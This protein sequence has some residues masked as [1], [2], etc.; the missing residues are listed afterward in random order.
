MLVGVVGRTDAG[1]GDSSSLVGEK[2]GIA[3]GAVVCR[4]AGERAGIGGIEV[5]VKAAVECGV[6]PSSP[7]AVNLFAITVAPEG[8]SVPIDVPEIVSVMGT[9]PF[10][11]AESE[12]PSTAAAGAAPLC[13]AFTT[14]MQLKM[15]CASV[16]HHSNQIW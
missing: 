6:D 1:A 2:T 4:R 10:T 7:I 9:A 15:R 3:S 8:P 11:L 13:S 16:S 14:I 5:I 12:T